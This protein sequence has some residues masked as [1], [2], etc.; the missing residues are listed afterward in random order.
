MALHRVMTP[1]AL[2]MSLVSDLLLFK[3][4]LRY[5]SLLSGPP[6]LLGSRLDAYGGLWEM[7]QLVP[8]LGIVAVVCGLLAA[9]ITASRTK[10]LAAFALCSA[11][12]GVGLWVLVLV[13]VHFI[14]TSLR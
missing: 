9:T 1:L 11:G 7:A 6:G 13:L 8:F 4:C 2:G 5:Y 10:R 12:S 14:R 3:V